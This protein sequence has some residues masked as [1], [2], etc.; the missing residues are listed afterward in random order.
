M[1]AKAYFG[2]RYALSASHR[3]NSDALNEQ[4]NRRLMESAIIRT[5]MG[6][7]TSW[8][9]WWAARWTRKRAW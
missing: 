5:G 2:R 3:L 9:C 8:K 1:S 7:I 4:E 6:T